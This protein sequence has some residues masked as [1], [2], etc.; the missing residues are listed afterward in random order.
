MAKS[1]TEDDKLDVAY[2]GLSA[3]STAQDN[4]V[5]SDNSRDSLS[6]IAEVSNV[7][8]PHVEPLQD[9]EEPNDLLILPLLDRIEDAQDTSQDFFAPKFQEARA[10]TYNGHTPRLADPQQDFAQKQPYLQEQ[11]PKIGFSSDLDMYVVNPYY[12]QRPMCG[13]SIG[14]YRREHLP[15]V[16]LGGIV[17]VD[18]EPY[19]LTVHHFL[20]SPSDDESDE[21]SETGNLDI[22]LSTNVDHNQYSMRNPSFQNQEIGSFRQSD[23]S[24]TSTGVESEKA[25]DNPETVRSTDMDD[26]GSFVPDYDSQTEEIENSRQSRSLSPHSPASS[27]ELPDD[28][29]FDGSVS[30]PNLGCPDTDVDV[31][32]P[33]SIMG[34]D[35]PVCTFGDTP[36][37][38]PGEGKDIIITQP[39]IDDV[40][41]AFFPNEEDRDEDHTSSHRFGH[42]YAS[43]G[44]RRSRRNGV[45]HE[46]DWALI[47]VDQARLQLYNV[48]QG[49]RRF[50]MG[51]K[52]ES[53]PP[54]EEPV[55]RRHY[56]QEE[57]EY[58]MEVVPADSL[59]G[60]NVHCFGRTT[61][62]Q[63]GQIGPSMR[64]VRIYRRKNLFEIVGSSRK[65]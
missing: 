52:P 15:P 36:G 40:D 39:S 41:E 3:S 46:I 31:S 22:N 16:S 37:I 2:H 10:A 19:G 8:A 38:S 43:S 24:P 49:G 60:L 61:G 65:L 4:F 29:P 51:S 27:V 26:N 42:I 35:A 12:Q 50:N 30:S 6:Q 14:A 5:H 34:E 45:L 47:E 28:E 57:D 59:A 17:L 48:V 62:L 11:A 44:V 21:E 54:L 20:D 25:T 58:P 33:D 56:V 1:D 53:P 63:G 9:N 23:S 32:I 55:S 13:A 18:G 64:S 7:Q